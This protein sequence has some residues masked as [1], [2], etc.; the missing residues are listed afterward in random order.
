MV[1]NE[2]KTDE[3]LV[4]LARSDDDALN[5]LI[6]SCKSPANDCIYYCSPLSKD[7]SKVTDISDRDKL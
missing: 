5:E 3:E 4:V 1:N 2:K 7:V 6:C